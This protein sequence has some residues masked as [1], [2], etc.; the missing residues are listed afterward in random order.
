M[1]KLTTLDVGGLVSS[2]FMSIFWASTI[3]LQTIPPLCLICSIIHIATGSFG[4]SDP[5][6]NPSLLSTTVIC[7]IFLEALSFVYFKYSH[8]RLARR[9]PSRH[10]AAT[11]D[12]RKQL[13][14]NC[15]QS[16]G[17]SGGSKNAVSSNR[18]MVRGWFFD[19]Q[20]EEIKAENMQHWLL[21]AGFDKDP[22]QCLE[23]DRKSLHQ[24]ATVIE[25]AIQYKFKEGFNPNINS[26]RVTI[27]PICAQPRP[28]FFYL[29][30]FFFREVVGVG[31]ASWLGFQSCTI[32]IEGNTL[33]YFFRA[34][35]KGWQKEGSQPL[36]FLHGVG[37]LITYIRILPNISR[38]VPIYLIDF[39][40]VCM[41]LGA[42]RVL[43]VDQ[44]VRFLS[45]IFAIEQIPSACFVGQSFGT[46]V[47]AWVL[48]NSPSLVS[49]VV[50]IDP[51]VFL[52]CESTVVRSFFHR[53]PTNLME[54]VVSS[55]ATELYVS[56]TMARELSWSHSILFA[57]DHP[58][59]Q[60]PNVVILS[61]KDHLVPTN[62]VRSYLETTC[63]PN[64]KVIWSEKDYHG[65]VLIS[66]RGESVLNEIH[67][68]CGEIKREP[69]DENF[70]FP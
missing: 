2:L 51:I 14:L 12:Q 32:K 17:L 7:W 4:H 28:L 23:E 38:N 8:A 52:L 33:R 63:P 42:D 69:T 37:G 15:M 6:S 70:T 59:N 3:F 61:A 11:A 39:P 19:A 18:Q 22:S 68:S 25:E 9:R 54:M 55:F 67:Q 62:Q 1:N 66:S 30:I 5:L 45:D 35:T 36:V 57:E 21:W 50:L 40:H 60:H 13:L 20:L 64:T 44:T 47:V 10:W 16:I 43:T 65:T 31:I 46:A 53:T 34:G 29:L 56:N 49:S 48:K 24:L 41:V 26:I 58:Q 27:D